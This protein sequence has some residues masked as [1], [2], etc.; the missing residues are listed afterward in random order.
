MIRRK[1]AF[2]YYSILC[3]GK[4]KPFFHFF[5]NL[6]QMRSYLKTPP[7]RTPKK[8]AFFREGTGSGNWFGRLHGA[9][10]Q[11]SPFRA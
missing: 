4:I 6:K 2:Y 9:A 11:K 10:R 7:S 3:P 5:I 1:N 8:L